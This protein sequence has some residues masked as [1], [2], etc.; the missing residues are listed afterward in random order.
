MK[1]YQT[2]VVKAQKEK[3]AAEGQFAVL[4]NEKAILNKALDEAKDARDEA[5]VM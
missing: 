1:T 2:T 5:I 4:E 3:E